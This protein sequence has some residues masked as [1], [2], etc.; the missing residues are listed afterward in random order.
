M[1]AIVSGFG[2]GVGVGE[3]MS[4]GVD[5]GAAI[6]SGEAV[7]IAFLVTLGVEN[8]PLHAVAST[9]NVSMLVTSE[10]IGTDFIRDTF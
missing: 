4:A 10:M 2:V 6:G 1:L 9:V 7:A 5:V 8:E 3:G